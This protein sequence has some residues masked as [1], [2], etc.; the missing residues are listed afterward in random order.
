MY[1]SIVLNIPHAGTWFGGDVLA[2]NFLGKTDAFINNARDVIDWYT[3]ELFS[4]TKDVLNIT[5]VA[6]P[7][8][9]T[10]CDVERMIDDPLEKENLGICYEDRI[11]GPHYGFYR[12]DG[13][14]G[15][16][17]NR[18]DPYRYYVEY[19]SRMEMLLVESDTPLLID[20]HSFSSRATAIL[21]DLGNAEG[22]DICIG[23]NEDKTKP[24]K[25]VIETVI[26]H[27]TSLGYNV[28][29]NEPFSNSKTFNT[30]AKYHSIMIEV[31]KKLYMDEDTL[32]KTRHFEALQQQIRSLYSILLGK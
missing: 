25:S 28:G 29:I 32:E 19:H 2:G 27:F 30:P 9:R 6:F 31:N 1:R 22:I 13:R 8:C 23:F 5:A 17:K 20:C 26:Q 24:D 12:F 16:R 14:S 3:D 18:I 11:R 15:T 7:Y 4:P 10:Y 21:K